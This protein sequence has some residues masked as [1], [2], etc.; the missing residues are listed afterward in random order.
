VAVE[1]RGRGSDNARDRKVE[2]AWSLA[3]MIA[4]SCF[5][6]CAWRAGQ[7]MFGRILK[8]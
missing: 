2:G 8:D 1:E 7:P 6:F 3:I 4:L 5:A